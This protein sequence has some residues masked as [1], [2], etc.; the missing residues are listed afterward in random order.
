MSSS[1]DLCRSLVEELQ[2]PNAAQHQGNRNL[3]LSV[4]GPALADILQDNRDVLEARMIQ[5]G[6][7]ADGAQTEFDTLLKLARSIRE[8]SLATS[9]KSGSLDLTLE[10]NWQ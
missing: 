10:V 1:V 9:V 2:D 4:F 3:V 7:E 8:I 5:G 6:R